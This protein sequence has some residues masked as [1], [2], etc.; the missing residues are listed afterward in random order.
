[1]AQRS[2]ASQQAIRASGVLCQ[3]SHTAPAWSDMSAKAA[4][5][6]AAR[7]MTGTILRM[8]LGST[9]VNCETLGP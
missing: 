1:M 7:R 8:G 2:V 9:P 5:T 4:S 6:A 3:P